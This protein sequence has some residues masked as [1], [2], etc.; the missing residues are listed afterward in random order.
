MM[1]LLQV[2]QTA[3]TQN[4]RLGSDAT[5][6]HWGVIKLSFMFGRGQCG[7]R[8]VGLWSKKM[9]TGTGVQGAWGTGVQVQGYWGTSLCRK[10]MAA[11]K[12]VQ[13]LGL[14]GHRGTGV[15]GCKYRYRVQGYH[16]VQK[17]DG[18]WYRGSQSEL[19]RFGG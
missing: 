6:C 4:R 13:V 14:Q 10:K 12:G 1:D 15:Q 16:V 8:Y 11:G 18:S 19:N 7:G 3:S 2:P 5:C 9:A 17:E